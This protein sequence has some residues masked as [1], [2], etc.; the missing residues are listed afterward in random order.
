MP[1]LT[2]GDLTLHYHDRGSGQPLIAAHAA[3]VSGLEMDWLARL[4]EPFGFRV[5]RP[6]LRGHGR[7]ENPAPDLNMSRMV[8]DMLGFMDGLGLDQ[9]HGLGYSMGGGLTLNTAR[10]HPQRYKSL[11]IMGSNYHAPTPQRVLEVL[12]PPEGRGST[13]RRVFDAITGFPPGWGGQPTDYSGITCPALLIVGDRDEFIDV[14]DNVALYRALPQAELCVVPGADHLGL[15]RHPI[16]IEALN[17]FY[18]R[19]TR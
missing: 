13:V 17:R 5:L 2:V 11:V 19:I 14:E 9:V 6:D 1:T 4:I 3:T 7:T 12:G 10:L 16:V 8:P 15:V 18:A